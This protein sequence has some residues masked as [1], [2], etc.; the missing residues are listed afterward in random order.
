MM[1]SPGIC[2]KTGEKF[3]L[4]ID[5]SQSLLRECRW[6]VRHLLQLAR[7]WPRDYFL[8]NVSHGVEGITRQPKRRFRR[9]GANRRASFV[10]L[11]GP[12]ARGATIISDPPSIQSD[13]SD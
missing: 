12:H 6:S 10:T 13:R 11:P 4:R 9:F 2:G 7:F 1:V 5:S 3:L 8:I